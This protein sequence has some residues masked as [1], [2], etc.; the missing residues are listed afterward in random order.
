MILINT[1]PVKR[2]LS[3]CVRFDEP[4]VVES[5][6]VVVGFVV[7]MVVVKVVVVSVTSIDGS[8]AAV[9][10]YE[11]HKSAVGSLLSANCPGL[12][13]KQLRVFFV[14]KVNDAP[15]HFELDLHKLKHC[16]G[17][18]VSSLVWH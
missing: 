6:T 5:A 7:S 8:T 18:N 2:V 9:F 4:G 16:D 10:V 12:H 1:S 11:V 3:S 15:P 14:S 17:V 13:K